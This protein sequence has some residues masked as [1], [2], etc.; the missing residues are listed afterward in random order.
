MVVK[1]LKKLCLAERLLSNRL[2]QKVQVVSFGRAT[3]GLGLSKEGERKAHKLVAYSP[4]T[5]IATGMG[6]PGNKAGMGFVYSTNVPSMRDDR[7]ALAMKLKRKIDRIF[8]R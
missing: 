8:A 3:Y 6:L 5:T 7:G 1:I 2:Y 4:R